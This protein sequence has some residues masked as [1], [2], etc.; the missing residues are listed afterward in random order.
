MKERKENRKIFLISLITGLLIISNITAVTSFSTNSLNI[1]SSMIIY[2]FI[3]LCSLLLAEKYNKKTVK[4]ACIT[5]II[6][7]LIVVFGV[8]VVINLPASEGSNYTY[9][10]LKLILSANETNGYIIP[11]VYSIVASLTAFF[12]SQNLLAGI[13]YEI[14]EFTSKYLAAIIALFLSMVADTTVFLFILKVGNNS[15]D[16]GEALATNLIIAVCGSL[17]MLALFS[18]FTIKKKKMEK[19]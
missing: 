18:I 14:K 3:F 6:V 19:S 1:I 15:L 2:P 12:I 8:S 13:Y 7:Q 5:A 11:N 4:F 16:I 10:A 9:E 17:L